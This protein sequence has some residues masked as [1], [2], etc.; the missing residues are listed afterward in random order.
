MIEIYNKS[1]Y[2]YKHIAEPLNQAIFYIINGTKNTD[3]IVVLPETQFLNF[4]TKRTADNLYDSLTPMY[5]ETFGEE[6]II[7]HFKQTMPEYF[8]LNNR[9]TSD[10]GKRYICDDY[11]KQFCIFVD[12]NYQKVA[13]F[14][15]K[16][17]T[18]QILKRKDLL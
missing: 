6:N 7:N 17:Y 1:F 18:L 10:Y 13:T 3:R 14:G 9:D 12:E 15:D 5:F 4:V 11:G 8:V 2:S 16:K